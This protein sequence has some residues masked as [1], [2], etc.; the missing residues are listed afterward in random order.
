MHISARDGA[1]LFIAFLGGVTHT[2][3][4]ILIH[5]RFIYRIFSG[6][7]NSLPEALIHRLFV[8]IAECWL[9]CW[10]L[11]TFLGLKVMQTKA[12]VYFMVHLG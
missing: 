5:G 2:I 1:A 9:F 11:Y 8:R 4:I 6:R 7:I 10:E 3:K 12:Q